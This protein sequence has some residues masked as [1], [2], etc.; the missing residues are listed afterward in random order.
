MWFIVVPGQVLPHGF[1]LLGIG[2]AF[3]RRM[4][5]EDPED[6]EQD[7]EF[8]DN[9][10]DERTAPGLVSET[11]PVEKPDFFEFSGHQFQR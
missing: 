2:H 3:H 7:E 11:I 6:S 9:E 4:E 10:P 1:A 5:E 8:K